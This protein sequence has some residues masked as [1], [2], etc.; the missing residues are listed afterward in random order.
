MDMGKSYK[1]VGKSFHLSLIKT[2]VKIKSIGQEFGKQVRDIW[3]FRFMFH[4]HATP[5]FKHIS[6]N[7]NT[8]TQISKYRRYANM[9]P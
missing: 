5:K 8:F 4:I 7:A 6:K 1:K 3:M 2:S 9:V